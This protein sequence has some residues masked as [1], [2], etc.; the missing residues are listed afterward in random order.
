[1]ISARSVAVDSTG[2]YVVGVDYSLGSSNSQWRI[3]KRNLNDGSL[4]WSVTS[5]PSSGSDWAY[6]VAVDSTGIYVVGSDDI[7]G[8]S[9]WRI[10][11]RSTS[12]GAL[13]WSVTSNPG[14]DTDVPYSVAVDSTG[15][16]VVGY[17]YISGNYE[18]RIEKRSTSTGALIWSVTSNPTSYTDIAQSVAVDSTGIYVVGYANLPGD[19][20][21][22]IEK[23]NLNDGSLIWSVTSNPSSGYDYAQSVAVD[24]TG[25]YMLLGDDS[26]QGGP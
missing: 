16:Y 14:S 21:W 10:E 23:R 20:Q 22:R 6:S 9:Q 12:T 8:N 18:W 15:I 3:E 2:I 25:V 1:M 26:S 5:N 11:K 13:I 19:P 17:D 24:N 7:P 4:I